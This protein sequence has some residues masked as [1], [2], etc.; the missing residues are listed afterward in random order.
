MIIDGKEI[1]ENLREDIKE[2]VN[3][4]QKEGIYPS[5][6][7]I[8]AGSDESS[9]IYVRNKS[10]ACEKVGILSNTYN[11][12]E[13]ASEKDLIELIEELNSDKK[14]DGILVQ[15]PLPKG[16]DE[17]LVLSKISENKDVDGFHYVNAGKV[18]LGEKDG[19]LP[20]T[21]NG[22]IQL[23]KSTGESIDGKNAVVIGRSKI[24]GRPVSMLLLDENATVT[25]CHTHTKN[26]K[27]ITKNADILVVA[28]GHKHLVTKDMVKEGAIVIDVGITRIDGK[29][30]G[31]VDFDNVKEV[32]KYITPVPGGVGPMTITM[33]LYNTLLSAQRRK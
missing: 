19:F 20:C 11:F 9:K 29:I 21:A 2:K 3:K 33:L 23:I 4:L 18:Y 31:D 5:L 17:K 1:S 12:P 16:I 22:I 6:S 24:V 25:I 30:Y 26:L 27:E 14:T 28:V 8:M 10:K 15:L 13:N 7:V 32:A